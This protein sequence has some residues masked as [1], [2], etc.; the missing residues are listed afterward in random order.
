MSLNLFVEQCYNKTIILILSKLKDG[1][2][3]KDRNRG[4]ED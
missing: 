2:G 4:R 3:V 1:V